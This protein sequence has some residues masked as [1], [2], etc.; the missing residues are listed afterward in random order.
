MICSVGLVDPVWSQW[1]RELGETNEV[2]ALLVLLGPLK[3]NAGTQL[4]AAQGP[5]FEQKPQ[6][7]SS[8]QENT[9]LCRAGV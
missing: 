1:S 4:V 6:N 7:L 5:S 9:K 3:A 2:P 8:R